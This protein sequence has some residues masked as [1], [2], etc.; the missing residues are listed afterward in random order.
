MLTW[1]R[2][3]Q[4]HSQFHDPGRAS[5]AFTGCVACGPHSLTPPCFFLQGD[6]T[7][8]NGTG[9]KSIYGSRFRDENFT[10]KHDRAGVVSMVGSSPRLSCV[11][12]PPGS[13][14]VAASRAPGQ[15]WAPQQQLPVFHQLVEN[16]MAGRQA[17]RVWAG[18]SRNVCR[19]RDGAPWHKQRHGPRQAFHFALRP[20]TN[21]QATLVY[22]QSLRECFRG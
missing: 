5:L 7:C 20:T 22:H 1:H 12:P 8:G 4:H 14:P 2:A 10:L 17:R 3:A 11:P 21:V 19:A 16:G 18:H 6:I 9:G 15:L 13:P